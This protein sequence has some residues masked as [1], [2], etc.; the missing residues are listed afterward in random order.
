[1]KQVGLIGWRGMVGSVLMQRMQEAQDFRHIEPTFFTTSNVGAIGPTIDQRSFRLEDAYDIEALSSM[2]IIITCQGGEYTKSI[3][4]KLRMAGWQGDWID[5]SSALRMDEN[6]CIILDPVNRSE[7]DEARQRGIKL[8]T[9][10]N[11]SITLSLLGLSGL[12]KTGLVEWMSLMT[13]QAASGAGANQVRELIEQNNYLKD[14]LHDTTK[15]ST[16]PILSLVDEATSI[17]RQDNF[18]QTALGAPLMGSLI[19]WIGEELHNGHSQE[20]LKAELEANKIL[21]LPP[22]TIPINGLCIRVGVFRCHSA[23]ITFKLKERIDEATFANLTRNAH[24][25]VSYIPNT[26][27]ES[28]QQLTPAALSGSLKIGV[29]RFKEMGFKKESIYSVLTV[30]DQLLWGAAEPLRRMLRILLDHI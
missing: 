8:F 15:I 14:H 5:S 18:P 22:K 30:G 6:A 10:G 9:G 29:G 17:L 2:D 11:C 16:T 1:M 21:G 24:D 3:Y 27:E 13:Y 23:A 28:V 25:W 4:T 12:L 19:P 20:E 26:K 7:I